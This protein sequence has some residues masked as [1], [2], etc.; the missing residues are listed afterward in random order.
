MRKAIEIPISEEDL[1]FIIEDEFQQIVDLAKYYSFCS[2]CDGKNKIEMVDYKLMLNDL[3]DIVFQGKC[4]TC[5]G[6]MTRYIETGEQARFQ[7]RIQIVKESKV[8]GN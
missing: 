7:M 4:K 5:S 6:R 3:D 8:K 1:K 2:S